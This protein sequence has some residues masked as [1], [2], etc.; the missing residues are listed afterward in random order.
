MVTNDDETIPVTQLLKL[1]KKRDIEGHLHGKL[2]DDY[3]A[4]EQLIRIKSLPFTITETP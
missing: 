1:L 2:L 3:P 4:I